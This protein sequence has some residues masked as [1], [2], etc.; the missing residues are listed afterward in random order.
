MAEDR[1]DGPPVG[2]K[3]APGKMRPSPDGARIAAR[4][5]RFVKVEV[6]ERKGLV[7]RNE[8]VTPLNPGFFQLERMR[9]AGV[10][11]KRGKTRAKVRGK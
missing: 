1:D 9:T 6:P 10:A 5:K 11:K 8:V 2:I 3:P 7:G 4:V